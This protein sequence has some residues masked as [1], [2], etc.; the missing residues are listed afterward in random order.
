VDHPT[1]RII[2]DINECTT[3]SRFRDNSHFAHV[4]FVATFEPR[5]IG[6]VL[7]DING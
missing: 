2:G 6:H 5:D 3:Q 4:A 7:S 1:L